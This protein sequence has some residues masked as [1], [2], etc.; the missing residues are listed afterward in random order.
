MNV[1]QR[2]PYA[3]RTFSLLIASLILTACGGSSSSSS[4]NDDNDQVQQADFQSMNVNASDRVTWTYVSLRNAAVVELTDEQA[5]A[6]DA[7]DIA[8]RRTGIR[9]NGGDSGPGNV[10]A[11]VADAQTDFY[12]DADEPVVSVFTNA[13]AD[14]EAQALS[15]TYVLADLQFSSDTNAQAITDWFVYNPQN[16][17]ISQ[18]TNSWILR[19]ADNQTFSKFTFDALSLQGLTLS[20]VTQAAGTDQF[21]AAEQELVAAFAPDT[22]ELCLDLDTAASVACT[23]ENVWDLRYE[24]NPAQRVVALWTNGG[25][26]GTGNGAVFG[27]IDAARNA[28]FTNASTSGNFNFTTHYQQDS[29]TSLFSEQSWYAY[30]LLDEHGIW[31]NFRTYVIDTDTTNEASEKFTLQVSNYSSLGATGTPQIR[32]RAISEN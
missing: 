10:A 12:N 5:E 27:P 17:T 20:Y 2:A 7:W 31:P 14:I 21:A 32:F 3:L 25:V 28:A 26:F 16:H 8:M 1:F 15:N 24:V 23:Q 6:S 9:L 29:S 18:N 4:D 30:D 22:T 11:A 19:H 13:D